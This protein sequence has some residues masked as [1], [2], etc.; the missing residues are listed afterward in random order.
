MSRR[1]ISKRHWQKLQAQIPEYIYIQS[2]T[3]IGTDNLPCSGC[4]LRWR[5]GCRRG[6]AFCH[7]SMVDPRLWNGVFPSR[8]CRC[9]RKHD[10]WPADATFAYLCR[11]VSYC[12]FFGAGL[13]H[14]TVSTSRSEPAAI[15]YPEQIPSDRHRR[16]FVIEHHSHT[17]HLNLILS[18]FKVLFNS[19]V[20]MFLMFTKP[21]YIPLTRISFPAPSVLSLRPTILFPFADSSQL[22]QLQVSISTLLT[23]KLIQLLLCQIP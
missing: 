5:R 14:L 2:M 11:Q 18:E 12:Q 23:L 6:W 9:P 21:I 7:H 16:R 3:S 22:R 17:P 1:S 15:Y 4:A 8:L 10:V 13:I 20:I 19:T